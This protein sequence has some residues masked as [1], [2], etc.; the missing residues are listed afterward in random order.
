MKI[1]NTRLIRLFNQKFY[2]EQKVNEIFWNSF[3]NS[4]WEIDYLSFLIKNA[5]EGNVFI[6]VG[7]WIGP[8][9]L[10]TASMGMRVYSFEPDFEAFR[11]L[12]KNIEINEFK[13]Q[14]QIFNYAL[15]NSRSKSVLYSSTGNFGESIS[16]LVP[17]KSLKNTMKTSCEIFSSTIQNIIN[18]NN[19]NSGYFIL[20][21]DIE[22]HE[23]KIEKD[24]YDIIRK[25]KIICLISYHAFI[26]N[27]N[28]ILKYYHRVK[29]IF[30]QSF[31]VKKIFPKKDNFFRNSLKIIRISSILKSY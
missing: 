27:H 30:F 6:D 23:F 11:I 13:Y 29:T 8:Y 9:T 15:S 18:N 31:L 14:P 1:K 24:I 26:F 25:N 12:K 28:L 21:I 7:S 5:N 16:T 3:E 4:L 19:K 10:L 2:V 22:G 17:N 20:K